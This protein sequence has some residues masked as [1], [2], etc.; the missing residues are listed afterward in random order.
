MAYPEESFD[1]HFHA[2]I[3]L[4]SDNGSDYHWL[5]RAIYN[6]SD[7]NE[8]KSGNIPSVSGV[9]ECKAAHLFKNFFQRKWEAQSC[10]YMSRYICQR[11]GIHATTVR[12]KY[13]FQV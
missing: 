12:Y 7:F 1:S 6:A 13:N 8:W 9:G 4:L 2:W 10:T 3:G 11:Q 5:D